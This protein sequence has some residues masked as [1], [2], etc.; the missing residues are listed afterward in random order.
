MNSPIVQLPI[1]RHFDPNTVGEVWRVPYQERAIEAAAW[2]QQ[3]DIMPAAKD[4]TRITVMPID[5]QNTF[6]IAD[7]E[8]FVGGQSGTGAIDDNVRLCEFIY[9]NLC[10]ITEIDPTMDTHTAMQIFHSIFWVDAQGQHPA[11]ATII[12]LDEVKNGKW[13]VNPAVAHSVANG[14][15][16][17]LQRHA[18]HYVQK[19]TDGGKY[20]LMIW[21]YHAM[22]GG[23][24]HALVSAVEEA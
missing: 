16:T 13:Q 10:L 7:F 12:T 18:L 3:H 23:I 1:P 5:C 15:Y 22:L 24:G 19:L 2:I 17:G 20:P 14:N 4:S 9:R 11:P 21:G 8:L 6:C